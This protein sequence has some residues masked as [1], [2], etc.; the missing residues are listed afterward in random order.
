VLF[1]KSYQGI[2]PKDQTDQAIPV[3]IGLAQIQKGIL[4]MQSRGGDK[5]ERGLD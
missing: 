3:K 5:Y 2:Y 1:E 4:K